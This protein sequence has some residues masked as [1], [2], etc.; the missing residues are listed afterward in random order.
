M[1]LAYLLNN[2]LKSEVHYHVFHQ[3]KKSIFHFQKRLKLMSINK[4]N[5][6]TVSINFEIRF[7]D[8]FKFLQTSLANR[9]ADL[10]PSYFKNTNFIIKNNT[11]ILR[12]KGV[13]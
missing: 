12:Q 5:G 2:L 6:E 4:K 1:I 3:L 13:L 9:V 11:K 10:Q 7:I 8:S